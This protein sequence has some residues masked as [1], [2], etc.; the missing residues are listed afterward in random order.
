MDIN[1]GKWVK[2]FNAVK[3][4]IIK[5]I[6]NMQTLVELGIIVTAFIIS[7]IAASILQKIL[8]KGSQKIKEKWP[9]IEIPVNLVMDHL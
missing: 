8:K 3:E 7:K 9:V 6:F 2:T 4:W 5:N 1:V